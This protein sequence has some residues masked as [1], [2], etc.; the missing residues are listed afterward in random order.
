[1]KNRLSR[2]HENAKRAAK[3]V[4]LALSRLDRETKHDYKLHLK[5]E[6]LE[7]RR[8]GFLGCLSSSEYGPYSEEDDS[9]LSEESSYS[10]SGLSQLSESS[11][12]PKEGKEEPSKKARKDFCWKFIPARPQPCSTARIELKTTRRISQ[13][14]LVSGGLLI[15]KT[16][17]G[18]DALSALYETMRSAQIILN[19]RLR[20]ESYLLPEEEK[21]LRLLWFNQGWRTYRKDL[22]GDLLC[23]RFHRNL[24]YLLRKLSLRRV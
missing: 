5:E 20:H 10:N 9:S 2:L 3:L 22:K 8:L 14:S 12:L 7:A 1:M 13:K 16:R 6:E 21:A 11:D 19:Y 23:E 15:P 17:L 4:P 24:F 18:I